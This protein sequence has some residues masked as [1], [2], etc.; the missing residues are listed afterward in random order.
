ME[1]GML[2]GGVD[3]EN[4]GDDFVEINIFATQNWSFL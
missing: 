4:N 3:G 1:I 2:D